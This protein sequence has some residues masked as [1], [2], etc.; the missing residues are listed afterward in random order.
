MKT[1]RILQV[2]EASGGGVGRHTIDL[3]RGMLAA[4]CEVHL[5]YSPDRID[6]AFREGLAELTALKLKEISMRR[7]PHPHDFA[8]VAQVRR[9]VQEQGPFD[10]I[11]GQSS[12]GGAIARLVGMLTSTPTVYTP[13]CIVTMAPTFGRFLRGAFRWVEWL[14]AYRTSAII[15]VSQD[16][17]DHIRTLGIPAS[18]VRLINN[19]V[20][21]LTEFDRQAV[22]TSLQLSPSA[23]IVGFIGRFSAQKNPELLLKAFA[24]VAPEV[25][26]ARLAFIGSGEL[27]E[28]LRTLAGYLGVSEKVD[29]LGYRVGYPCMPAFDVLAI[30]S[31]YEAFPYV[32]I[33]GVACQLPILI[34]AVG[35]T[36]G[37]IEHGENGLVIP[38]E[39]VPAATAALRQLLTSAKLRERLAAGCRARSE[40]FRIDTM[41][42]K[43]L[44]VY[45]Q[46]RS[47]AALATVAAGKG[48]SNEVA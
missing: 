4:G 40:E 8:V 36:R 45:D 35:G 9:Y 18:K 12:K 33:E 44:E 11:H 42:E 2:C 38:S 37:V 29:W 30:P 7:K 20:E 15:A 31:R 21:S 27:E 16:E 22:R 13:H 26:Q 3:C 41:V 48:L 24:A 6:G 5:V 39:D 28:S 19:G 47:E 1:L 25:P 14:L 32:M 23:L 17:R 34:T 46:C 43:T 10:I